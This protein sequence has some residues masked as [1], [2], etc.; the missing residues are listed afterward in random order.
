MGA[1]RLT[2][3]SLLSLFLVFTAG[4]LI[5]KFLQNFLRDKVLPSTKLDVGGKTA[6]LSG[7]GYLGYILAAFLAITSAGLNLSSLAIVAGALS[8]GLGFGMQTIVS[9]FVSGLIMLVER[10][11]QEGDWIEVGGYSGTVKQISVR[12]TH[13]ETFN[14]QTAIIPNSAIITGAV[15]NW[16]HDNRHGRLT[17]PIEVAYGTNPRLVEEILL[18]IAAEN[19]NILSEPKPMVIFRNFGESAL[20]FEL[21]AFIT[22]KFS[23]T[24]K[25]E[26]NFEIS[27]IFQEK[28]I[29]I[30]FPQRDVNIIYSESENGSSGKK[31]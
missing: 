22:E 10:P 21:R 31:V 2:F 20:Q 28:S 12:A 17:V 7:V 30:P 26:I 25:S 29:S 15:L 9:N 4:Y 3:S 19:L 13:L 18:S 27:R 1:G 11:I 5:T 23:L 8:V 6:I 16:T 14:K 24:V